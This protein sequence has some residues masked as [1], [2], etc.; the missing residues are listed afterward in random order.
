MI[1]PEGM[2][3]EETGIIFREQLKELIRPLVQEI[4]QESIEERYKTLSSE[5]T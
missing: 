5:S 3:V 4:F 2:T 1:L